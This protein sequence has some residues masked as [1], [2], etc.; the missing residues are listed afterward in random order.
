MNNVRGAFL[1]TQFEK[2]AVDVRQKAVQVISEWYLIDNQGK[3]TDS[4]LHC[5]Q[6]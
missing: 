5:S 4:L 2:I 1:K 6:L 3:L